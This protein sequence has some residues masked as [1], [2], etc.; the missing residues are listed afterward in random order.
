M[1]LNGYQNKL[2]EDL[3][4]WND[5]NNAK[6]PVN[7]SEALIPPLTEEDSHI[8]PIEIRNF[9]NWGQW[10]FDFMDN[11]F[12][13]YNNILLLFYKR[14]IIEYFKS[15]MVYD[16]HNIKEALPYEVYDLL[17][18]ISFDSAKE[19][20]I[21]VCEKIED[22][23]ILLNYVIQEDLSGFTNYFSRLGISSQYL[24]AFTKTINLLKHIIFN[25]VVSDSETDAIPNL[26]TYIYAL[27]SHI[28]E[29]SQEG[30]IVAEFADYGVKMIDAF[31]KLAEDKYN[32]EI[33]NNIK[34]N[35]TYK[36]WM[37]LVKRSF[38]LT[39]YAMRKIW[40]D[41]SQEEMQI[42]NEVINP[43]SEMTFTLNGE[44]LRPTKQVVQLA[45]RWSKISRKKVLE[46]DKTMTGTIIK[47][48]KKVKTNGAKKYSRYWAPIPPKMDY[49]KMRDIAIRLSGKDK[50]GNNNLVPYISSC[51]ISRFFFF[52][53]HNILIL[54]NNREINFS[55][56]IQWN[57]SWQSFK[58]LAYCLYDKDKPLPSN[59]ADVVTKVFRFVLERQRKNKE[60]GEISE[61]T[62]NNSKDIA[63]IMTEE[64]YVE[65][66]RSIDKIFTEIELS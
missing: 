53:M 43:E 16:E 25:Q 26:S 27:K 63:L 20:C 13:P 18:N 58:Y 40:D 4:Y 55:E 65:E 12:L 22:A 42:A 38:C 9:Y 57:G 50:N 2:T 33:H 37:L 15:N 34:N 64:K 19:I 51:D 54:G 61:S 59:F 28:L 6:L 47:T 5:V 30:E 52:F 8:L 29:T 1:R 10:A 46:R 66:K 24:I 44:T 48:E 35:F 11:V 17:N 62:F 56:P 60:P 49:I 23:N 14:H 39:V 41:L 21:I 7:D 31:L 36:A 3:K 45:L 32:I